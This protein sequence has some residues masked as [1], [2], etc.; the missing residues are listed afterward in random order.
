MRLSSVISKQQMRHSSR[1]FGG[2]HHRFAAFAAEAHGEERGD[3]LFRHGDAEDGVGVG[4][5]ALIVGDNEE[6]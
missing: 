3:A 1:A 5:G 2:L 6:L 4:N